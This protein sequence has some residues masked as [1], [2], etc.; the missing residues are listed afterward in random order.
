MEE[1]CHC[2]HE[3]EYICDWRDFS[4]SRNM[5]LVYFSMMKDWDVPTLSGLIQR[6]LVHAEQFWE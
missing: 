5:W 6:E 2:G 4:P 1:H 3:I